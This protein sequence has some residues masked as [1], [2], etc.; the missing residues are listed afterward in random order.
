MNGKHTNIDK[1]ICNCYGGIPIESQFY[2]SLLKP[3]RLIPQYNDYIIKYNYYF[4]VMYFT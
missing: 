1:K 4:N 2:D 3:T